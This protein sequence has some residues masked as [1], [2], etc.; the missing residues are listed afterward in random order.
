M[1]D[2][3]LYERVFRHGCSGVESERS[4]LLSEA[5]AS[6]GNVYNPDRVFLRI[7]CGVG[8]EKSSR[9]NGDRKSRVRSLC[10]P[11]ELDLIR[12]NLH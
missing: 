5:A 7:S 3:V 2:K 11:A 8:C 6:L 1:V 10:R 9:G 4:E 12:S